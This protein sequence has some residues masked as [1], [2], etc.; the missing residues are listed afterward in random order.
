M[1]LA[2][3][4][5]YIARDSSDDVPPN[6]NTSLMGL[7]PVIQKLLHK[8]PDERFQSA[9]DVLETLAIKGSSLNLSSKSIDERKKSTVR[10]LTRLI[11][12]PFR[13]LRRHEATDFLAVSLPD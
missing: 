7:S 1:A 3:H 5:R 11:V 12:L 6:R 13:L 8:N 2:N 10:P 9:A 4:G